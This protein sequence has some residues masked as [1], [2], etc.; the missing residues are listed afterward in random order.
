MKK[1]GYEEQVM[2]FSF[3]IKEWKAY[4]YLLNVPKHSGPAALDTKNPTKRAKMVLS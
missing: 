1:A 3:D 4:A 2:N